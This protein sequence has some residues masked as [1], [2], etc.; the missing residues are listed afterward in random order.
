MV[1]VKL[2][3]GV[4]VLVGVKVFVGTLVGV[5][6]GAGQLEPRSAVV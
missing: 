5:A 2:F 3:V 1:G 6:G 4:K